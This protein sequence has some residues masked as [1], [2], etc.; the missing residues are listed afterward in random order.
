MP[1]M[2]VDCTYLAVTKIQ[3]YKSYVFKAIQLSSSIL[4]PVIQVI[5][6]NIQ[7]LL[8]LSSQCRALGSR[9]KSACRPYN[10]QGILG[11]YVKNNVYDKIAWIPV[12]A[13]RM[14]P[15][16]TERSYSSISHYNLFVYSWF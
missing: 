8:L 12:S 16:L 2:S 5:L 6:T 15:C 1:I 3:L 7:T 9:Y 4:F 10:W 13:T 14:T 11:I